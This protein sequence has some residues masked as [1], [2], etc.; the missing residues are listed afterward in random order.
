M[1]VLTARLVQ[2]VDVSTASEPFGKLGQTPDPLV[3]GATWECVNESTTQSVY[4]ETTGLAPSCSANT[5]IT[6]VIDHKT[7]HQAL[8]TIPLQLLSRAWAIPASPTLKIHSSLGFTQIEKF[9]PGFRRGAFYADVFAHRG[10]EGPTHS[11]CPVVSRST[12]G[13]IRSVQLNCL[14]SFNKELAFINNTSPFEAPE[15][16]MHSVFS[17]HHAQGDRRLAANVSIW[18][19]LQIFDRATEPPNAVLS[20][21]FV[22]VMTSVLQTVGE[23]VFRNCQRG[24]P[25]LKLMDEPALDDP[26]T[27]SAMIALSSFF[28]SLLMPVRLRLKITGSVPHPAL[29]GLIDQWEVHHDYLSWNWPLVARA[30]LSGSSIRSYHNG[31]VYLD[32]PLLRARTYFWQLWR[33][34][35]Q[36]ALCWWS[37]SDW[38]SNPWVGEQQVYTAN[39]G[40]LIYP[41]CASLGQNS[42]CATAHRPLDSLRWEQ[43]LLGLQDV[44]MLIVLNRS[45]TAAQAG[46]RPFTKLLA[47]HV[48]T[49]RRALARVDEITWAAPHVSPVN[50]LT[51]TTNVSLFEE[52]RIQIADAADALSMDTQHAAKTDD[53]L[54]KLASHKLVDWFV[55]AIAPSHLSTSESTRSQLLREFDPDL[56]DWSSG[57]PFDTGGFARSRGVAIAA[58]SQYEYEESLQF[59]A[60]ETTSLLA[61]SIAVNESGSWQVEQAYSLHD[62]HFYMEQLSPQWSHLTRQGVVRGVKPGATSLTSDNIA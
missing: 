9:Q 44:E 24:R 29:I 8:A 57:L 60:A 50:D 30:R 13:T 37:I 36:G 21:E 45:L 7:H 49:A 54:V 23:A 43:M 42:H 34:Q 26:F 4:F 14:G 38:A 25:Y 51:Y 10:S 22:A 12:N 6:L 58:A 52:I 39:S 53:V 18:S 2:L 35:L 46:P 1:P 15:L 31:V 62:T 59:T 20:R 32:Q 33:E 47:G 11:L 5:T 56:I 40:V 48:D 28:R 41:P 27:L 55:V 16:N 61:D 3:P 17:V 19:G